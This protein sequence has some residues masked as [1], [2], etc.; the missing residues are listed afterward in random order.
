MQTVFEVGGAG[1]NPDQPLATDGLLFHSSLLKDGLKCPKEK[2]SNRKVK[3]NR[4]SSA[5]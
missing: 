1:S 5:E 2:V 3:E 4:G